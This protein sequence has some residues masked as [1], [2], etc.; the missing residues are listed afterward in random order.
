MRI[1]I[2]MKKSRG[3]NYFFKKF[4]AE[5]CRLVENNFNTFE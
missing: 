5:V 4:L 2:P 1:V 3:L